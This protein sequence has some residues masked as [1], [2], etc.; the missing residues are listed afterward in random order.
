M[1][2]PFSAAAAHWSTIFMT[3]THCLCFWPQLP[4]YSAVSAGGGAF[5][6]VW[7]IMPSGQVSGKCRMRYEG[8]V[9]EADRRFQR[10]FWRIIPVPYTLSYLHS[11]V[12]TLM[13]YT[14][15][16]SN[17]WWSCKCIKDI[18][19][20]HRLHSHWCCRTERKQFVNNQINVPT[21]CP[22]LREHSFGKK[23]HLVSDILSLS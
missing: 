5:I 12:Y 17:N 9:N 18:R 8:L 19:T 7:Q 10:G 20:D 22:L 6:Q 16:W 14:W 23:A 11:C 13:W 4:A 21:F 15:L 1:Q 3:F 2:R